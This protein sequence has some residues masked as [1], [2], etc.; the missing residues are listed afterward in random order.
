MKKISLL[1]AAALSIASC[2]NNNQKTQ[3]QMQTQ[4]QTEPVVVMETNYGTMKIQLYNNTPAHR[5]NFLK[6][7]KSGFYDGLKFHRVIQGFMI[8]GGDPLSKDDSTASRW[9][10]GDVGYTIPAE[11]VKENRH[12][13]GALAAAR[14]G[15][16]ANP[17]RASS[18]CQFYIVQSES[19]CSHLDGQ[20]TVYGQTIEGLDV[21]D[22]IAA[23][24]TD[25]YDR[26]LES[27][28]IKS[29][30]LEEPVD[31]TAAAQAA[32]SLKVE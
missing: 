20:Y 19:G 17:R 28:I 7:T 14:L 6:L 1:L 26:P 22:K 31:S 10:T 18:G 12:C 3:E 25:P 16:M 21:I 9:G 30:K 4:S 5:D 13:K 27:V 15:D 24:S 29:V 32:D 2:A 8:Q 11:F 23:V